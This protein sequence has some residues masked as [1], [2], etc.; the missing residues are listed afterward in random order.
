[1]IRAGY[2]S[3]FISVFVLQGIYAQERLV[4]WGS[5]EGIVEDY[6]LITN[7]SGQNG[8]G[9]SGAVSINI[10]DSN[11]EGEVSI[12]W[13]G[14]NGEF[15]LGFFSSNSDFNYKPD[16]M[17][18]AVLVDDNRNV[19]I[20][21]NG[22][23]REGL[24]GIFDPGTEI[25]LK[26]IIGRGAALFLNDAGRVV[27]VSNYYSLIP[28]ESYNIC[29]AIEEDGESLTGIKTS[30]LNEFVIE[31][32]SWTENT[33]IVSENQD[34]QK[35]SGGSV[36]NNAA[37]FSA[38]RL[39]P[40]SDG[41]IIYKI[42]NIIGEAAMG[43]IADSISY[44]FDY[45]T[46]CCRFVDD[47]I[48]F[49][50]D[51]M[52]AGKFHPLTIGDEVEMRRENGKIAVSVN[53]LDVYVKNN[54]DVS[55]EL[56]VQAAIKEVGKEMLGIKGDFIPYS[57]L[58]QAYIRLVNAD[59]PEHIPFTRVSQNNNVAFIYKEIYADDVPLKV[60]IYDNEY[61]DVTSSVVFSPNTVSHG[62]NKIRANLVNLNPGEQYYLVVRDGMDRK[63]EMNF[64]IKN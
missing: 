9:T 41:S 46:Y 56:L 20:L 61:Q 49:Y 4:E 62:E 29:T 17:K 64:F 23:V 28:G 40:G 47:R 6:G 5:T 57:K 32:E 48:F 31:W 2:I 26:N 63:W 50:M 60:Q 13:Q 44:G 21:E 34:I 42:H 43:L 11:D 18:F 39:A 7:T 52:Y 54:I 24:Y 45:M 33:V 22:T 51:G 19:F 8:F 1:M 27:Q 12:G 25:K 15:V 58:S 14:Q 38:N 53:G 55:Q 10:F 36:W 37:A 30:F 16:N 3:A 35:A 59:D